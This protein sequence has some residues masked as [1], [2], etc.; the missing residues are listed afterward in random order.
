MFN[1]DAKAATAIAKDIARH[2]DLPLG[3]D[4]G[5]ARASIQAAFKDML[6][7]QAKHNPGLLDGV[8]RREGGKLI[9]DPAMMEG[10]H[11][12]GQQVVEQMGNGPKP[13]AADARRVMDSILE[14]QPGALTQGTV[15]RLNTAGVNFAGVM[16]GADG[17]D[18][19]GPKGCMQTA[20]AAAKTALT[21]TWKGSQHGIVNAG[22]ATCGVLLTANAAKDMH[23]NGVNAGNIAAAAAGAGATVLGAAAM[24]NK[25]RSGR[26][27]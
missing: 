6:V 24:I 1:Q 20:M 8:V 15:E 17:V 3:A 5:R 25:A 14:L 19:A 4:A 26:G 23:E 27:F 16:K 10:F 12:L 9:A 18:I 13:K 21:D 11:N 2:V 7:E 22:I